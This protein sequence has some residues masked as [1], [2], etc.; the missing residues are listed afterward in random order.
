MTLQYRRVM[1][2]DGRLPDRASRRARPR[3]QREPQGYVGLT[4]FGKTP[5]FRAPYGPLIWRA[6][7]A[8]EKGD[9]N[10]VMGAAFSNGATV[11]V[12]CS[13]CRA[14]R[15]LS[16]ILFSSE[17]PKQRNPIIV[18]LLGKLKMID[19]PAMEEIF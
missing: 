6:K 18:F 4:I 19:L 11:A 14:A 15:L 3:A 17:V 9:H 12:L 2:K 5:R 8:H 7:R 16:T 10:M 13:P 1:Y